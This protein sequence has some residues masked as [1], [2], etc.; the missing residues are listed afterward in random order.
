MRRVLQHQ[1]K[2]HLH[3]EIDKK[4]R[5]EEEAAQQAGNASSVDAMNEL[6]PMMSA[7]SLVS[8]SSIIRG[9]S[10]SSATD[11][12][13]PR[14]QSTFARMKRRMRRRRKI[15][16]PNHV[17]KYGDVITLS[18]PGHNSSL[19]NS[20]DEGLVTADGFLSKEC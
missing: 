18:W 11:E 7:S 2:E 3:H 6:E 5:E 16:D 4:H 14:R 15:I 9:Q 12:S 8:E 20:V 10:V 17:L 19:R 13:R 1:A